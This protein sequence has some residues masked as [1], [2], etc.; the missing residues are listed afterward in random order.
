VIGVIWLCIAV[1]WLAAP[2]VL[3][4]MIWVLG[5]VAAIGDRR[6]IGTG[7]VRCFTIEELRLRAAERAAMT[8]QWHDRVADAA[9]R[10]ARPSKRFV[11][12]ADARPHDRLEEEP[13]AATGG[14]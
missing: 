7:R 14:G 12:E 4:G 5:H 13:V 1:A 10:S 2:L 9:P 8:Q 11:R 3:L 6:R